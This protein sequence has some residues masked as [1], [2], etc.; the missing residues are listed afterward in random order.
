MIE[1]KWIKFV[2]DN[3]HVLQ[4]RKTDIYLVWTKDGLYLLGTIRWYAPWRKYCFYPAAGT[5]FETQCLK[6]IVSFIDQL[7]DERKKK[8]EGK[9]DISSSE[10]G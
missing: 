2:K 7:M 1:S 4:Q 6:D 3:V 10:A 8:R 9:Q 5:I